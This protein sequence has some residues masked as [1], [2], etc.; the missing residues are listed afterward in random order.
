MDSIFG[1]GALLKATWSKLVFDFDFEIL[2]IPA[3]LYWITK[4]KQRMKWNIETWFVILQSTKIKITFDK[5]VQ[6]NLKEI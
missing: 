4:E 1:S 6:I 3:K 2:N 5:Y